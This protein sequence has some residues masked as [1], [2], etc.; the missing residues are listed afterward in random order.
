MK[1]KRRKRRKRHPAVSSLSRTLQAL[2]ISLK[3]EI[4]FSACVSVSVSPGVQIYRYTYLCVC[5]CIL[6][7]AQPSVNIPLLFGVCGS[8]CSTIDWSLDGR[9]VS[10]VLPQPNVY[11][12]RLQ[13]LTAAATHITTVLLPHRVSVSKC[14]LWHKWMLTSCLLEISLKF[15]ERVSF[16]KKSFGLILVVKS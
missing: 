11:S 6:W 15:K 10:D 16:Q 4:D 9:D 12:M 13:A 3:V 5:V 14:S 7:V 2:V 8:A 1:M